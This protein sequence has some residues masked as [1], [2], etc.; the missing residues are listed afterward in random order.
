M[1]S[2]TGITPPHMRAQGAQLFN[3]YIGK[4][5]NT[6]AAFQAKKELQAKQQRAA[7]K[8]RLDKLCPKATSPMKTHNSRAKQQ[9][10][11]NKAKL[12][13]ALISR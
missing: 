11:A 3:A 13:A 10:A 9:H 1:L 8:A 12:Y 7:N 4:I 5:Q 2:H 6:Y